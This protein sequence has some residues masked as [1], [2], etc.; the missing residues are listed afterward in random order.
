MPRLGVPASAAVGRSPTSR[1]SELCKSLTALCDD[2]RLF[3][4]WVPDLSALSGQQQPPRGTV[5]STPAVIV[6]DIY[7]KPTWL[8]SVAFVAA[9]LR[10]GVAMVLG[11]R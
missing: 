2:I 4:P 5:A 8:K 3:A 6:L 7:T 10:S 1:C 11:P 9:M